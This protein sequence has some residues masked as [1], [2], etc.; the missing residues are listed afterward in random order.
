M[1]SFQVIIDLFDTF[2]H[3]LTSRKKITVLLQL[4]F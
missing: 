4:N 3:L 2:D 1:L